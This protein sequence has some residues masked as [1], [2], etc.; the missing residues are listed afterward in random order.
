M[1]ITDTEIKLFVNLFNRDGWVLDFSKSSLN[2][3][4]KESVGIP[5]CTHYQLSK[6]KSLVAYLN[7]APKQDATKLLIDMFE[8]YELYYYKEIKDIS[9]GP[10]TE[11][12]FHWYTLCKPIV[13]R[14]KAGIFHS[15]ST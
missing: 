5:I 6:G 4:T 15:Y 13:K 9:T 3:F 2:A 11:D 8:Y 7:E 14:E 1:A 12:Y 10:N